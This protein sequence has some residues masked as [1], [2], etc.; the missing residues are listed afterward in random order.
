MAVYTKLSKHNIEQLLNQYDIGELC[1]FQEISSGIENTNYF[2][3]TQLPDKAST[4]WVLTLFENL[5]ASDLPYFCDLTIHLEQDGFKVPAPL[6]NYQGEYVFT[7]KN[8]AGVL[9]PCLL[10]SSLVTPDAINCASVGAYLAGM[11]L[12]L[13]S[14]S[15]NRAVQRD[16]TWMQVQQEKLQ[17]VMLQEEFKI[18]ISYQRIFDIHFCI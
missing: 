2:V 18:L 15:Q 6:K 4:R 5:K 17:A 7:L 12:S 3:I 10:G 16:L 1:D 13:R 11:H 9:V 8:K 14:F